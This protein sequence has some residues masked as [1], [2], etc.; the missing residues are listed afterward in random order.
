[1]I[2]IGTEGSFPPVPFLYLQSAQADV[3]PEK[4][5]FDRAI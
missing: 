5:I 1:M 2:E 3:V 4:C